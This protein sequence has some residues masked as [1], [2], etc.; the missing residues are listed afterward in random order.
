MKDLKTTDHYDMY[1]IV[2][3]RTVSLAEAASKK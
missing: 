3:E 1:K 2:D